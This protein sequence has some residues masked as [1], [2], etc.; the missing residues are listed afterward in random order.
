[1]KTRFFIFSLALFVS[2]LSAKAQVRIGGIA[3][4][5]GSAILDLNVDNTTDNGTQGLALPRVEL[6]ATNVAAPITTPI[7]GLQVYNTATDGSGGTAVSPGIYYWDGTQWVAAKGSSGGGGGTAPN[8][9]TLTLPINGANQTFTA[10]QSS[11]STWTSIYAPTTAGT[12]GQ[13]L[14]SGGSGAAPTWGTAPT[15]EATTASNGLTLSTRD[16]QLGGAL[17]KLTTI[18][19]GA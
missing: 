4:P 13:I 19:P 18:T 14:I 16:V 17:T 3:N 10:D 1:M 8:N 9:G 12:S 6:T 5:H 7:K 11:N 2:A 15:S